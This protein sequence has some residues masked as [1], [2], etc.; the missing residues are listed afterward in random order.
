MKIVIMG[1]SSSGKSTQARDLAA[2]YGLTYVSGSALL[3]A[4]LGSDDDPVN[5]F[6]L[7]EKGRELDRQRDESTI[8]REVD[9]CLISTLRSQKEIIT[10][11]WTVPWL[12]PEV[13]LVR[14]YLTP[15]LQARA[16]RAIGSKESALYDVD[17]LARR[18]KA[19]DE[20]SRSRFKAMYGFDILD[21]RGFDLVVDTSYL[22]REATQ[23]VLRAYIDA[24]AV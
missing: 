7:E 16:S 19:K 13:D 1:L 9:D 10:D 4:R 11:S 17:E 20:G 22:S 6:W 24:R 3:L 5:H 2:A 8:D 23:R 12:Y 14:V 15:S 18:L 21:T